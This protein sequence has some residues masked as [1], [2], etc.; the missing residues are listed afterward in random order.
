MA[1]SVDWGALVVTVR[2]ADLTLVS[3]G[4]YEL[5]IVT[6]WQNLHDIQDTLPAMGFAR[7]MQGLPPT[8]FSPRGVVIDP[9]DAG[10]LIE[11]ED[12]QYEVQ[13]VN[14]NSD[15]QSSRVQNQVSITSRVTTGASAAEFWGYLLED[16]T[17]AQ[18]FLRI[19]LASTAGKASGA[20]TTEM[21][22]RDIADTKD[23]IVATVDQFGNREAITLD[24]T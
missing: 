13:L 4:V 18:E 11:F 12:G 5:D 19:I 20:E 2:Q 22:F 23:R 7:I 14:G 21:R 6:F 17:S 16:T 8:S 3:P 24:G 10:W 1:Y 15:V 9:D